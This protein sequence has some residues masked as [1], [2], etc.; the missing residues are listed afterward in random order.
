MDQGAIVAPL[1]GTMSQISLAQAHAFPTPSA[2][3]LSTNQALSYQ[4]KKALK[5][6]ALLADLQ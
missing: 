3:A 6:R 1:P 4:Q 2:L 5:V